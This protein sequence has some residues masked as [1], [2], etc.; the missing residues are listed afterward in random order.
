MSAETVLHPAVREGLF[1]QGQNLFNDEEF[2]EAHEAWE[3]LWL[4]ES[5]EHKRFVQGLIQAAGHFVHLKKRSNRSGA[6]STAKNALE[7]LYYP[8]K[9]KLYAS[10]DV[11]PIVSALSYNISVLEGSEGDSLPAFESFLCPKLF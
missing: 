11:E 1:R 9:H 6:L 8:T 3:K 4:Q 5:E 7:K 10:F 2:F